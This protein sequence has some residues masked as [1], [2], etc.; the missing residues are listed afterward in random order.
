MLMFQIEELLSQWQGLLFYRYL[1]CPHCFLANEAQPFHFLG[2]WYKANINRLP[3]IVKIACPV[4]RGA[5]RVHLK[6]LYPPK[7]KCFDFSVKFCFVRLTKSLRVR[8]FCEICID[9]N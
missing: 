3:E 5:V 4:A 1:V 7:S 6:L 2:E 9:G 8:H